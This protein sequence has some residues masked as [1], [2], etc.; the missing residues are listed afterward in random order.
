MPSFDISSDVDWQEIDNA[1]NQTI[2][3]LTNRFD[4]KAIKFE[5]Q[6][7]KK[8]KTI[9]LWCSEEGKLDSLNDSLQTKVIKRGL[10]LLALDYQE[11]QPATGDSVR[12]VIC[13]QAGVS[14]EKGKD[15]IAALKESKLKIQ[16][17]IQ[18]EKVRVTAKNKDTLQEAI[19]FLK[20]RQDSLKLPLQFGNYRD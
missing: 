8:E 10:S 4:F 3:E 13:V 16:S 1:I 7:D 15:I 18:D 19:Q 9:T 12:Q 17:Q 2:K 11:A 14:K 6:M 5:I 20:G